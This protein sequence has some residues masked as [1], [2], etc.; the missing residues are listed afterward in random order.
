VTD[1]QRTI[2]VG[3]LIAAAAI[4]GAIAATL[5]A[6]SSDEDRPPI[7]VKGGGSLII[8]NGVDDRPGK[9]WAKRNGVDEFYQE[10]TN[11]KPVK[12]FQVY[13][14]GGA[15]SGD[16]NNGP[17]KPITVGNFTVRFD[18]D[19]RP[20][21]ALKN[22][23][24]DIGPGAGGGGTPGPTVSGEGLRVENP[25]IPSVLTAGQANT[26]KIASVKV[27]TFECTSPLEIWAEPIKQ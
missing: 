19:E 14:V 20:D 24:V 4:A 1:S 12:W 16:P 2:L 23:V 22:Y 8:Q 10:H 21:T 17:C 7:I 6:S 27:A 9:K 26:G 5:L 18:D 25:N 11:G 3:V 13:F 15:V